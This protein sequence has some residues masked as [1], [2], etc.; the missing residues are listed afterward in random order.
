MKNILRILITF[1]FIAT[2]ISPGI[3]YAS[4]DNKQD[5]KKFLGVG[6]QLKESL[7]NRG[8]KI[9]DGTVTAKST[10]SLTVTKDDKSYTVLTTSDSKFRRHFWGKSTLAEISIGNKVNVWGNWADDTH[11]SINAMM[12]RNLSIMK[13]FGVFVGDIVSK[14]STSFVIHSKNRADQTVNFDSNTKFVKKNDTATIYADL[15]IEDR[16]KIKG[17]WDKTLN[18]ISEVTQVKDYSLTL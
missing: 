15:K 16:V 3:T 14:S 6:L 4:L 17:L 5:K 11:A 13:R 2:L 8:V 12:I 18:T 10:T 1:T 9:I 7:K